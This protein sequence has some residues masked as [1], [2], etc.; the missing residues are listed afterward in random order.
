MSSPQGSPRSAPLLIVVDTSVLL[1][2]IATDTLRILRELRRGFGVQACIVEAVE[3]E[4]LHILETNPRFRGRQMQ[5]K[6]ALLTGAIQLLNVDLLSTLV[7]SGADAWMRQIN[8]EGNRLYSTVDRGEA[9]SHAASICLNC[10]IATNDITAVQRLIRN[11]EH[12]PRPILRFWDVIVFA[13]QVGLLEC[14]TCDGV[15]KALAKLQERT[16]PAFTG[17][18]FEDGLPEYYPRLVAGDFPL[19]GA[20]SPQDRLDERWTVT[21]AVQGSPPDVLR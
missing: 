12:I 9:F 20:S 8:A 10:Q 21:Q 19:V 1:Q 4:A 15:R 7:G 14:S 3:S 11:G 13:H 2:L 6:K 5:L 17:K 18:S 16:H